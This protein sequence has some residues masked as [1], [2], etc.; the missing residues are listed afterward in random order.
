MSLYTHSLTEHT[1]NIG[2]KYYQL[3]REALLIATFRGRAPADGWAVRVPDLRPGPRPLGAGGA[4]RPG[5][6]HPRPA[7]PRPR[8]RPR[9]ARQV[10]PRPGAQEP[11]GGQ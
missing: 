7:A 8:P 1:L 5:D 6:G 9:T 4:P 10:R 11:V 2:S 3:Q